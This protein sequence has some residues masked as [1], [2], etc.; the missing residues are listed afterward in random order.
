[1]KTTE[2]Q[3]G[4]TL[5]ELLVVISI[6]AL[7]SSVVLATLSDARARARNTN[8][9]QIAKQYQNALELYHSDNN[10]YPCGDCASDVSGANQYCLGVPTNENCYAESVPGSD[11]L[12]TALQS[13][14]PDLPSNEERV[15]INGSNFNGILFRCDEVGDNICNSYSLIWV[16][17]GLDDNCGGGNVYNDAFLDG[18]SNPTNTRCEIKI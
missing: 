18:S 13:Y 16:T 6:I 15:N 9:T 5:I 2:Q 14:I 11:T 4:F 17:E 7:L 12:M 8:R 1:M 3:K 10:G